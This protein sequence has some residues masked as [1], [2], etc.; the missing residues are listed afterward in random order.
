VTRGAV[1]GVPTSDPIVEMMPAVYQED[2][3]TKRFTGG[4]DEVIAPVLS[5]LDCLDAYLDPMVAPVDFLD[6][7]ASWVGIRMHEDVPLERRRI[8]VANAVRL[9]RMRGTVTGLRIQVELLTGGQ[10]DLRDNGGVSWSESPGGPLPGEGTPRLA[11]RVRTPD[12]DRVPLDMLDEVVNWAK[13]A[14]VVH[15]VE[16][17]RQ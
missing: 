5:A 6:W 14:H 13:P 10:V 2:E 4:L 11:V 16:V 1:V 7:L 9:H 12:P 17:V 8:L 15:R 3:F